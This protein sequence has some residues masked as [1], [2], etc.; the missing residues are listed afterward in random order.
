MNN[1]EKLSDLKKELLKERLSLIEK[2][3]EENFRQ[4]YNQALYDIQKYFNNFIILKF[5]VKN[6][7]NK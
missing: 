5:K 4:G 2:A 7:R 1:K 6:V 3:K